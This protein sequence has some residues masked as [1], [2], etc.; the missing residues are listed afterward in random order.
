MH[1][2]KI[3]HDPG[4]CELQQRI[5]GLMNEMVN[6]MNLNRPV[7]CTTMGWRPEADMY[8]TANDIVLVVNLAGVAKEDIAISYFE[9]HLRVLGQR[10]QTVEPEAVVR[11]H[12]LEIALGNFDRLF[13]FPI[14]IDPE[15]IEAAYADGLLTIRL[16]K[17]D[18]A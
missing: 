7:L 5:Q 10:A 18:D 8:E 14:A 4:L 1:L 12:Q 16:Q 15:G 17:P 9:N 2:I 13:R 6:L 3:I 11:C